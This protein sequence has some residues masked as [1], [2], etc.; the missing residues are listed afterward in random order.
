MLRGELGLGEVGVSSLVQSDDDNPDSWD[1]WSPFA[2]WSS[3]SFLKEPSIG[4]GED[5]NNLPDI[6]G[7][8][9]TFP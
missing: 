2:K 3:P 1:P 6:V 5:Q 9:M 8:R 4:E 7:E